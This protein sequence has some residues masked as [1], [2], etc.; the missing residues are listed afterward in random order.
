MSRLKIYD[1]AISRE[2]I[3]RE[4]EWAYQQLSSKEKIEALHRLIRLSAILN[5]Q[6][7]L[8]KKS[9][10]KGVVISKKAADMDK[11]NW[12]NEMMQ[13]LKAFYELKVKYLIVGGFAVNRYGYNRTTGDIDIYLKDTKENRS[14]LVKALAK[15]DYGKFDMLMDVPIIAGYC[16]IMMDEGIY[17]DLMTNIPGL[18]KEQFDQYYEIATVDKIEDYEIRF[19]HYN[20]LIENKRATGRPKDILDIN[21]LEK[22]N[23]A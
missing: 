11:T 15:M 19:L 2:N 6:K 21:E 22:I 8:I 17:A 20:H 23:K 7:S 1:P 18:E 5:G 12:S 10:G 14:N 3:I 9:R 13:L 4:R 16:E